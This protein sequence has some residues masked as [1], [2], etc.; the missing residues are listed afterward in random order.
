VLLPISG[1]GKAGPNILFGEIRKLLQNFF[2]RHS[3]SHVFEDVIDSNPHAPNTGLTPPLAG[4][5]S[6]NV[7]IIH[8]LIV[9]L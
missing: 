3:G 4:F 7:L 8:E 1:I 2:L 6:N 5:D 9:R